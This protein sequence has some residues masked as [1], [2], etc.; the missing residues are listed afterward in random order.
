[1]RLVL[2]AA[3]ALL[4]A[5]TAS[6]NIIDYSDTIFDTDYVSAGAGGLRGTGTTTIELSGV[7]GT[8]NR[9]LL[10]WHGPTNSSDP[11]FLSS[12]SLNGNAV[13]G[14]NIG[15]SDDNFWS[16]D[17]S[18]AYRADVTSLVTG[19]GDYVFAGL[20]PANGNGASLLV[21]FDDLDDANNRDIVLFDGND[22]NF[23]NP[24]DPLGWNISLSGINY[25]SG[26]AAL[27]FIVSDG[28]NFSASDDGTLLLN[29]TALDSGGIF[30]GDSTPFNPATTVSNG[31][32]WD[33]E[34]YDITSFLTPGPNSLGIQ[35][36]TV[37]DALS[38]IVVAVDLP[39]GAA[40][41][42]PPPTNVIPLPAGIA[43]LPAGLVGL[44]AL[45]RRGSRRA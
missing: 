45:R 32:L 18:Q 34:R 33:I 16:A 8:V 31:S 15:F 27:E 40:P 25:S 23:D 20:P 17:N 26:P 35:F 4:L 2:Y 44:A 39:A 41:P 12:V 14:T 30:Q 11:N 24:F 6:A 38:A 43:L 3:P 9:A 21:F 37:T 28:Q 42:P 7:S 22:A 19:D 5:G 1:M 36:G 29:G 10:Y 13:S